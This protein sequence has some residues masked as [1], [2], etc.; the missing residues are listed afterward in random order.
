[1]RAGK[2]NYRRRQ[3][4]GWG[5]LVVVSAGFLL[6]LSSVGLRREG[7]LKADPPRLVGERR[8]STGERAAAWGF[9]VKVG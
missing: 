6:S 9:G 2:G 1:V 4:T 5:I 8:F 3:L 7:R